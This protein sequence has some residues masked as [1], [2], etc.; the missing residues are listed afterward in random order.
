MSRVFPNENRTLDRLLEYLRNDIFQY[1]QFAWN[2]LDNIDKGVDIFHSRY[3][4]NELLISFE[5]SLDGLSRFMSQHECGSERTTINTLYNEEVTCQ[6]KLAYGWI[7]YH[8]IRVDLLYIATVHLRSQLDLLSE[9]INQ[10]SK[11][12]SRAPSRCPPTVKQR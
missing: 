12:H 9:Q 10:A 6:A 1:L 11:R 3:K 2:R 4:I 5:L 7:C 8:H